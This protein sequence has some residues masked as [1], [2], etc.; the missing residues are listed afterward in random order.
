MEFPIDTDHISLLNT[1]DWIKQQSMDENILLIGTELRKNE[2]DFETL[3]NL[4]DEAKRDLI[5]TFTDQVT[6]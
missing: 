4:I 3:E 2:R 1:A 6:V 5:K